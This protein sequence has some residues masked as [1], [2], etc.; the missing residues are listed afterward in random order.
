M[1]KNRKKVKMKEK[2]DKNKE[3]FEKVIGITC[4]T[5]MQSIYQG[6]LYM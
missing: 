6:G 4:Y 1:K 3:Y 2:K 5:I